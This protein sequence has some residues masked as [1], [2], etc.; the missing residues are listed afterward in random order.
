[1]P[2]S[3]IADSHG[4]SIFNFLRNYQTVSQRG[5]S[6]LHAHSNVSELEFLLNSTFVVTYSF[7]Y[8]PPR[9]YKVVLIVVL[10]CISL[11]ANSV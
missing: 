4:N 11:M 5:F 8:S 1:M 2:R 6:I 9:G 3:R 10:V 7:D